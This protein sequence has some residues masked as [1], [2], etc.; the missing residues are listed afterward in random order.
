MSGV[1]RIALVV[2]AQLLVCR[3]LTLRNAS[4]RV[5]SVPPSIS[6]DG[7][8]SQVVYGVHFA[9]K[10]PTG[11]TTALQFPQ[12][13]NSTSSV[14][15]VFLLLHACGRL[16]Q[17]WFGG[18][19]EESAIAW[20]LLKYN[21]A[22]F[23]PDAQPSPGGCW[24]PT[25]DGLYIPAGFNNL[26]GQLGLQTLPLYGVGLSSGGVMLAHLSETNKLSFKAVHFNVSPGSASKLGPGGFI[27]PGYPRASF[28]HMLP[29]PFAP[30]K[31]IKFATQA[32]RRNHVP[33]QVIVAPARPIYDL[34]F[35]AQRIGVPV[36]AMKRL[37][38]DMEKWGFLEKRHDRKTYLRF[39]QAD[40]VNMMLQIHG[41]P[42]V[43]KRLRQLDAVV[44]VLEGIH[45]PTAQPFVR[46]LRFM[47]GGKGR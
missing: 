2:F 35:E 12:L 21:F 20:L 19:P 31:A 44:H 41:R 33:T 6:V 13:E 43:H 8:T 29:D 26:L 46:V 14:Q 25:Y 10:L 36:P 39:K 37:I 23:A 27:R 18:L 32:L 3:A 15:G 16:S 5:D 28:V 40:A 42:A 1:V 34:L 45:A 22:V 7:P 4:A 17:D 47:L 11:A 38:V 24:Q 30:P 9:Y